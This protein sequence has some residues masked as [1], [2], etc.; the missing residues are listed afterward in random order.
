MRP[1][2]RKLPTQELAENITTDE[3]ESKAATDVRAR[4]QKEFSVKDKEMSDTVD[5]TRRAIGDG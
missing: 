4:E 1:S 2:M 3:S 5:T